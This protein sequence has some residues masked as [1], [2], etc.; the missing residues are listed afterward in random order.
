[1][2]LQYQLEVHGKEGSDVQVQDVHQWKLT[3]SVQP[4]TATTKMHPSMP[5]LDHET[6]ELHF[7]TIVFAQSFEAHRHLATLE[8]DLQCTQSSEH[9][10]DEPQQ[11]HHGNGWRRFPMYTEELPGCSWTSRY[12]GQRKKRFVRRGTR[13]L[14]TQGAPPEQLLEASNDF[15]GQPRRGEP[16]NGSIHRPKW[17]RM[18]MRC[19]Q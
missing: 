5:R 6:I 11:P 13:A 14:E 12:Q 3:H 10:S 19:R 7:Q 17:R 15:L 1:M 8:V 18:W 4:V 2:R 9:C 16:L